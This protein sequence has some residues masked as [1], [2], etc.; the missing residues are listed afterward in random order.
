MH[1]G[2]PLSFLFLLGA[3]PF[4]LLLH[5]LKPKGPK[6]RTTTLFLWERVLKDQ[7]VGKSLSWLLKKNLLLALQLLIAFAFITALADPS[8]VSYGVAPGDA[9]VVIDLSAS[10]KARG[11]S[12]TRFDEARQAFFGLIDQ[13]RSSQRMMVIGAAS[14]PRVLSPFTTDRN[15][16]RNLGRLMEATDGP[17]QV[18]EA[19]LF[20]HSFLKKG[21]RDHVVV[22]TDG[23]FEGAEEMPPQSSHLRWI[24]VPGGNENVGITGFEFRRAPGGSG[25][26]EVMVKVKNF[27]SHP[28]RA[29]LTLTLQDKKWVEENLEIAPEESLIRVYPHLGRLGGRAI[30][31][32]GIRDDLPTDNEAFLVLTESLPLRLLYA[33]KGNPF[34]EHLFRSLPQILVTRIAELPA[35]DLSS[36]LQI[37]DV[38]LIDGIPSPLLTEGNFILINTVAKNLPVAVQGKIRLPQP[39]PISGVHPLTKG[40]RLDNLTIKEA[41]RLGLTGEGVPL[42]RSKE[43]ALI[44][45]FETNRLKA[46]ILGFEL[47]ASDLPFRVAFPIL[48]T[49][50]LNWFRPGRAEFPTIQLQAGMPYSIELAGSAGQVEIASPSGRREILSADSNPLVFSDTKEVGFYKF[51][52]GGGE[53]EFAVNLFSESESRIAPRLPARPDSTRA[54]P[55]EASAS[56]AGLSLW[57]SLLVIAG[58]LLLVESLLAYRSGMA[59]LP[60][61]FRLVVFSTILLAVANPRIFRSVAALDVIMA[62]DFSHS[63][64][65]E[66][67]EIVLKILEEARRLAGPDTRTGLLFFGR[68]PQWEFLPRN[69]Y[70]LADFSPSVERDETDIHGAL[71]AALAQVGE[72][73]QGRILLI[74]D[75]NENR[76]LVSRIVPLLRSHDVPVWVSAINPSHG[77][78]E[79]YISDLLLPDQVDDLEAF[80]VK[81]AIE[82]FQEAPARIKLLRDGLVE[83]DE[84]LTLRAGTNWVRFAQSLERRGNHTYELLVES[85][86]DTL[87]ENNLLQGVVQVKGPPRILYLHSEKSAQLHAS[88]ALGAQGYSVVESAPEESSLSLAELSAF[89]L[90][91]LDNVPAFRLSQAK[92][93]ALEKYVMDLGGGLL[94]LGGPQS[95]GAGGY[96]RTPLERVL[97]VEMRPPARLD[98]PHI[99]I[100]F[101]LDKSGSMGAG[102]EGTTKLDL[103]K[104]AA[105][106]AADLLNPSD[107][108]GILTFDAGWDWLLPFRQVG[109]GEWFHEKLSSLQSEGGTDLY[110]AMTEAHR[111]LSSKAAAIKHLLVLSDGLTDKADFHSLVTKMVRDGI[112]ISIVAL[113]QDADVALMAGIAREGKGRAYVTVDPASIPQIFTSEALLVSRDLIIEKTVPAEISI[114]TGPLKGFSG[115]RIP[116]VRGYVLTHPKPGAELLMK[117]AEDPLLVSWRY[118]LG[119]VT[120][121]SSDLSGRWGKEWIMWE[122][123]PQWIG[124]VARSALRKVPEQR[125]RTQFKQQENKITVIA[126]LLSKDGGF[127][128]QRKLKANFTGPDRTTIVKSFEQIAPGRYE[129]HFSSSERGVYF[130]TVHD[131]GE[132]GAPP[133]VTATVPFVSPYPREYRELQANRTLLS[134]LAEQTG[135]EALDPEQLDEGLRRLFTPDPRK[136]RSAGESWWALS[137]LGLCLFLADLA[138]RRLGSLSV[139]IRFRKRLSE[140]AQNG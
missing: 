80:E 87:A 72:R 68:Q 44:C 47:S 139:R 11:R 13:M 6:V 124:Q 134:R 64:G 123:F 94:V 4:I 99:A 116:P 60:A 137:S 89:D 48:M 81:G 120:A 28:V 70:P 62:V 85:P 69:D 132:T 97:P 127:V 21:S 36:K 34:L 91:V 54:E 1:W 63:A 128:N 126:D 103:A 40:V 16:V 50:A 55:Y 88:R 31:R 79:I 96:Y 136:S 107:Q 32:L 61:A 117:V 12:G 104:S 83:K 90:V 58:V 56:E 114:G 19:I 109:K 121:F 15:R 75:G 74:S 110:K 67:K 111:S 59:L 122:S 14:I 140:A 119:K 118:G 24:Q 76:G 53:G 98:L 57:P 33:G 43:G 131:Q 133:S 135:G 102:P 130:V 3:V 10:M 66:G 46:L 39:L 138:S 78:N 30:A 52:S 115:K 93:E 95:Y 100:L 35:E 5:S 18:K 41:M 25:G 108:A 65:Q 45:A 92:M 17:G 71:Q 29:P 42:A 125:L 9:V 26:Y 38:V 129:S 84:T 113:G 20:A 77:R 86:M 49:N 8:L 101:L 37:Y 7:P 22:V 105:A 82:S 27:T 106:A 112:T 2:F 51:K 73:R 23:A